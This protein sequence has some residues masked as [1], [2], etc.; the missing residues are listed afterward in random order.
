MARLVDIAASLMVSP[1]PLLLVDACSLLDILRA[2]LPG[3]DIS[4]GCMP[5]LV[6]GPL[7]LEI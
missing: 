6:A 3:R 1:L 4:A 5:R 7:L 2:P